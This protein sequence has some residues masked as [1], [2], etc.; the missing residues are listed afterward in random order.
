MVLSIIFDY[1]IRCIVILVPLCLF[2]DEL[3]EKA[4][5]GENKRKPIWKK[6]IWVCLTFICISFVS[7]FVISD[8][9]LMV[10]GVY[11][12]KTG[13]IESAEKIQYTGAQKP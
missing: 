11:E 12:T 3:V 7:W 10:N 2:V 6:G 1:V 9:L 13:V 4:S 5:D 8:A